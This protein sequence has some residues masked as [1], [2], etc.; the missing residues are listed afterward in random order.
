M[1][2][3]DGDLIVININS[4]VFFVVFRSSLSCNLRLLI[5]FVNI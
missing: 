5:L 4:F 3:V 2:R 1:C